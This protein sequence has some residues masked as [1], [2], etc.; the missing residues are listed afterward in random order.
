[1]HQLWSQFS[2]KFLWRI[3][4]FVSLCF[5]LLFG[6]E[7]IASSNEEKIIQAFRPPGIAYQ[8][9]GFF[10]GSEFG[11]AAVPQITQELKQLHELGFQSLVTYG[12]RG[13]M[14]SIPKI[15]RAQGFSGMVIM[16]IWDIYSNEEWRNAVAQREFVD[17]YCLGNE[18]LLFLRYTVGELEEKMSELRQETGKPV[19][20]GEPI[21]SYL[22]GPYR[23]WLWK[24]SDWIFP[25]THPFWGGKTHFQEA[26]HWVLARVD[27]LEATTGRKIILKETG[28]PTLTSHPEGEDMQKAFF[29]ELNSTGIKF[30]YFEAFDQPWKHELEQQPE[31][32]GH[33]GLYDAQG[34]PKKAIESVARREYR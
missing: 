17:G 34:Q 25:N 4:G 1:M 3:L 33:W 19:T 26:V 12:A 21:D 28:L 10:P 2:I 8:P 29:S 30:V 11:K 16:G 5:I 27:Y 23:E 24:H 9:R 13:A 32:E 14:G 20:T 31:A 22:E 7:V 15:A 18:G 6:S